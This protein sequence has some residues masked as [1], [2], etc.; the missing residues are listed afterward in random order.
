MICIYCCLHQLQLRKCTTLLEWSRWL[1]ASNPMCVQKSRGSAKLTT[2]RP[3]SVALHSSYKPKQ[4]FSGWGPREAPKHRL[5]TQRR[6]TL[7]GPVVS[8]PFLRGPAS[9][10]TTQAKDGA[11]DIHDKPAFKTAINS[12][13]VI[14]KPVEEVAVS[15]LRRSHCASMV[16]KGRGLDSRGLCPWVKP[17]PSV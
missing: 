15:R 17:L 5:S 2:T 11:H 12:L 9:L 3:S 4:I 6:P 1:K 7:Q 16:I 10:C 14:N 13:A 8:S